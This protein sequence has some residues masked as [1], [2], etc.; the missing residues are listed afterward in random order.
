MPMLDTGYTGIVR[1]LPDQQMAALLLGQVC[2]A[3]SYSFHCKS[4]CDTVK[5]P[6]LSLTQ[7]SCIRNSLHLRCGCLMKRLNAVFF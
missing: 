6:I 7:T 3:L 5:V 4:L 1:P 2:R